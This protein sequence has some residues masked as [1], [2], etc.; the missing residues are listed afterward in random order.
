[1]AGTATAAA[2][3]AGGAKTLR[4]LEYHPKT[5]VQRGAVVPFTTRILAQGRIR[6]GRNNPQDP[7]AIEA[8]LPGFSGGSSVY[9]TPM[10]TLA[11]LVNMSVH[12]R[13]LSELIAEKLATT[14]STIRACWLE[15]ADWGLGGAQE[16]HRARQWIE[17]R[18]A[19]YRAD[20]ILILQA[21][22]RKQG[23]QL[24]DGLARDLMVR[25]GEGVF[26]SAVDAF[27]V[28]GELEG[29]TLHGRL[30]AIAAILAGIGLKTSPAPGRMRDLV[31]RLS[32]LAQMLAMWGQETMADVGP[33]AVLCA[34][35]ALSNHDLATASLD[36]IDEMTTTPT[37]LVETWPKGGKLLAREVER[38]YWILDGWEHLIELWDRVVA[39]KSLA[40]DVIPEISRLLPIV[41]PEE[42]GAAIVTVPDTTFT[43]PIG[44]RSVHE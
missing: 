35:A 40:E 38:L 31:A 1:M 9:V 3:M 28:A 29:N 37:E 39:R 16:A 18:E 15:I 2:R 17:A 44:K 36:T 23:L 6:P 4:R 27:A 20:R 32:E 43:H 11:E 22:A 12:D 25:S 34:G 8:L 42:T 13:A 10:S 5:F 26:R 7:A 14:P 19:T 33:T 24:D 41:P 30:N 21:L